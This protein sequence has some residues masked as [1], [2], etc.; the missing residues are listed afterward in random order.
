MMSSS[1]SGFLFNIDTHQRESPPASSPPLPNC[2]PTRISAM[3]RVHTL[4]SS[5]L[6]VH[7]L[8]FVAE[9]PNHEADEGLKQ[10]PV[11]SA[12]ASCIDL[13]RHALGGGALDAQP[14]RIPLVLPP[15]PVLGLPP[16]PEKRASI[17]STQLHLSPDK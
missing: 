11:R 15:R 4:S 5:E 6:N 2:P 10:L 7:G 17:K 12:P 14:P 9:I 16:A 3:R 8:D 1:L 13:D